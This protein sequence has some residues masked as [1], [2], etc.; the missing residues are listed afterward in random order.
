MTVDEAIA[1]LDRMHLPG[2]PWPRDLL[3]PHPAGEACDVLRAGPGLEATAR[4]RIATATGWYVH[5]NADTMWID[6]AR[7]PVVP[8]FRIRIPSGAWWPAP[9]DLPRFK[10]AITD[11]YLA[12]RL[13]TYDAVLVTPHHEDQPPH[14]R[15]DR[16]EAT[17]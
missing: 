5:G 9:E 4:A 16:I 6:S 2:A 14:F 7:P 3:E 15:L 17:P 1:T 10:S 13:G 11:A 12:G 8:V